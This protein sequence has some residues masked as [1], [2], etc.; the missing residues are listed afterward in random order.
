MSW[1][2]LVWSGCRL[3]PQ[4]YPRKWNEHNA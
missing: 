1:N 2:K 4:N 3:G